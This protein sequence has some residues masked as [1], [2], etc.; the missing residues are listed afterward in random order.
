MSILHGPLC[1]GTLGFFLCVIIGLIFKVVW[2]FK[3]GTSFV[4]ILI[5]LC[6]FCGLLGRHTNSRYFGILISDRNVMSLSRF[7]SI[8][9]TIVISSAFIVIALSRANAGIENPLDIDMD[10]R[11]WIMMGISATSLIASP[12]VLENKMDKDFKDP[13]EKEKTYEQL[14][15]VCSD[16]KGTKVA[17]N[18]K[19]ILFANESP[20]KAAFTDIFEGDEIGNACSVDI[21]KLQMFFFTM[22]SLITYSITL[23]ILISKNPTAAGFPALSEG[24]LTVLGISHVGYISSKAVTSTKTDTNIKTN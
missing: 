7:Q 11:I 13:R 21:A 22:V 9:W 17:D 20:D 12:L 19:G 18:S 2:W 8:A 6:L 15:N 1:T 3:P 24:F 23:Y 14:G 16:L 10:Y 4:L 5:L